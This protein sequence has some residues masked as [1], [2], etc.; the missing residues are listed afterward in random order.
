MA[1]GFALIGAVYYKG[2]F[3]VPFL[4]IMLFAVGCYWTEATILGIITRLKVFLALI[5]AGFSWLAYSEHM[6]TL[7]PPVI[8]GYVLLL[9]RYRYAYKSQRVRKLTGIAYAAYLLGSLL[10]IATFMPARVPVYCLY[11]VL[12]LIVLIN[13]H[14]YQ[15]LGRRMGWLTAFTAIPFH[16]LFY[17]YSGVAL[18]IGL[19]N[20]L[21]R[22][23]VPVRGTG[24]IRRPTS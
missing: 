5:V 17:F 10:F 18:S 11:T 24:V 7:I 8:V 19:S 20:Y 3:I 1:F 12:L 4:A 16:V 2:L 23:I 6:L 21:W 13:R 14:F 22:R 9:I 15:F